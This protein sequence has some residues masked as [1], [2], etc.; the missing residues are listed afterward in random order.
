MFGR[1]FSSPKRYNYHHS[2]KS[3]LN[4][5]HDTPPNEELL[6]ASIARL[7][8]LWIQIQQ[9][10]DIPNSTISSTTPNSTTHTTDI[11]PNQNASSSSIRIQR[12][13]PSYANMLRSNEMVHSYYL[14]MSIAQEEELMELIR[15]IVDLVVKGEQM[16]MA[17]ISSLHHE[18]SSSFMLEY[19]CETQTFSNMI[20]MAMGHVVVVGTTESLPNGSS[21][22]SCSST[23][24]LH[25]Y[26]SISIALQIIQSISI[27]LTN[28]S[29]E[30]SLY[31]IL[32]NH[33]I[34]H[35]IHFPM[36]NYKMAEYNK[37]Q[38]K[39][40]STHKKVDISSM[41]EF[42]EMEAAYIMLLKSLV[43]RMNRNTLQFYLQ[44]SCTTQDEDLSCTDACHATNNNTANNNNNLHFPLYQ[45]A[46]LYCDSH[47][48]EFIRVTAMNICLNTLQLITRGNHHSCS[49]N[50][51][52]HNNKQEP[53]LPL[54]ERCILANYTC[55][56]SRVE[57][58]TRGI[59][60]RLA[61][62]CS[63]LDDTLKSLDQM[64]CNIREQSLSMAAMHSTSD[65]IHT[66]KIDPTL[67]DI[68]HES[69][70]D[71]QKKR[72]ETLQIQKS[73]IVTT[74]QSI[75]ADFQ[76]EFMFLE[77][78]FKVGLVPLNEQI[79]ENMFAAVI[80]PLIL[81]PLQLF[82]QHTSQRAFVDTTA[83]VTTTN[84]EHNPLHS[85]PFSNNLKYLHQTQM[86]NMTNAQK[87]SSLAKTALFVITILF[88]HITHEQLLCLLATA[89][90]HPK[91]PIVSDEFVFHTTPNV[92]FVDDKGHTYIRT[93]ELQGQ[94]G[95]NLYHFGTP[96]SSS[97]VSPSPKEK[98]HETNSIGSTNG[99]CNFIFVP[100]LFYIHTWSE[101]GTVP[102]SLEKHLKANP[103]RHMILCCLAGTDG[104][105]DLQS[106]ALRVVDSIV[107]NV[108]P[109][110]VQHILLT[111]VAD[112]K[113]DSMG[114]ASSSSHSAT[115]DHDVLPISDSMSDLIIS[116]LPNHVVE[117]ITSLCISVV[118]SFKS[119]NDVCWCIQYNNVA[120]HTIYSLCTME[121]TI[122]KLTLKLLDKRRHQSLSFL[123]QKPSLLGKQQSETDKTISMDENLILDRMVYE[124]FCDG[125]TCVVESV[126]CDQNQGNNDLEAGSY[127][128]VVTKDERFDDI[129]KSICNEESL[130][131]EYCS[132]EAMYKC[133][134]NSIVAYLKIDSFV[135]SLR[136]Y[137]DAP[138]LL[139]SKGYMGVSTFAE[140]WK[141]CRESV[142]NESRFLLAPLA[143]KIQKILLDQDSFDSVKSDYKAGSIVSL[144]G[145]AAYP[146]VCEVKEENDSLFR[147]GGGSYVV[148][149]GIKWQSVYLVISDS[150]MMLAE[151]VEGDSGGNGRVVISTAL[152]HLVAVY[153]E[154]LKGNSTSPARR[155]FLTHISIE[156]KPP[157]LFVL[158]DD[159]INDKSQYNDCT[160]P[161]NHVQVTKSILDV[162]FED[163]TAARK[164]HK[165]LSAKIFK[166]RFK[167]GQRMKDV[168]IEE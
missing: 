93:D 121:H 114:D 136:G 150:H 77:D 161:S 98:D 64:D 132:E 81:T 60:H 134:A 119:H 2:K 151:A 17:S 96:F 15:N 162:W 153:D 99:T 145:K 31:M 8:E 4:D 35:L 56:P 159:E 95:T 126:I 164:A 50:D 141:E 90:L 146:C 166:A 103:F 83:S 163:E 53:P 123:L 102:S 45:R 34:H 55:D 144:V 65:G 127:F 105:V 46:L 149:D 135:S 27:L 70:L 36:E 75:V 139:N 122:R 9:E 40:N 165:S 73:R 109:S 120:A 26:P 92:T 58:L 12:K 13:K 59:F 72:M 28:L 38:E 41:G 147:G 155:L 78:I 43:M 97:S 86:N 130:L 24:K 19:F 32:S 142:E 62:L 129:S 67:L 49:N 30:T 10:N 110:I 115:F 16:N 91:T 88:H 23:T 84:Q 168:L 138:S 20:Q 82:S 116:S 108:K 18:S 61:Y 21:S 1:S 7:N 131:F 71:D 117:F 133:G 33:N 154:T 143:S 79:M 11:I 39:K 37:T 125:S 52:N 6:K 42:S 106:M 3:S 124:P 157:N 118:T 160:C 158:V 113:N 94:V 54:K 148:S 66:S 68:D 22:S 128:M 57:S 51:D 137:M 101:T 5:N 44:P 29:K 69:K 89:L 107:S 156:P 100:A 167:R 47:Q 25:L 112:T 104:M 87:D 80:Y 85:S 63:S 14:T 74:F 140:N 48:D 152:S 76:Y 111:N